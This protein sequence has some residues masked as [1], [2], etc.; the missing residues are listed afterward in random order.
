MKKKIDKF[1]IA[2]GVLLIITAIAMGFIKN[3]ALFNK[4]F[5]IV[6]LLFGIAFI[7]KA[8]FQFSLIKKEMKNER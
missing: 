6:Y 7:L 5:S 8:F 3:D 4:F 2:I 1:Y